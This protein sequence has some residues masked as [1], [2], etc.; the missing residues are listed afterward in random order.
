MTPIPEKHKFKV[1]IFTTLF[2]EAEDKQKAEDIARDSLIGCEI[3]TRDFDV[4]VDEWD[5]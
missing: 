4:D 3:K 5:D 2:V 1:A